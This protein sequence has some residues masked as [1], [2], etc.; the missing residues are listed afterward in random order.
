MPQPAAGGRAHGNGQQGE[1]DRLHHLGQR[2]LRVQGAARF[3]AQVEPALG[4]HPGG[5]DGGQQGH[6]RDRRQRAE[7][8][9]CG[10]QPL[11]DGGLRGDP[12]AFAVEAARHHDRDDDQQRTDHDRRDW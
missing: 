5:R 7:Q 2:E 10:A 9:P 8:P 12:E 11:A 3:V 4:A 1:H 6:Q